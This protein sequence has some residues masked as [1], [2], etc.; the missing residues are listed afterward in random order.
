MVRNANERPIVL[1][2]EELQTLVLALQNPDESI[3]KT[4]FDRLYEGYSAIVWRTALG[5]VKRIEIADEIKQQ[6]FQKVWERRT[7]LN[8]DSN[9]PGL[10]T[11]ISKR[12]ALD[13]IKS[14]RN[15]SSDP[16]AL[17]NLAS[18]EVATVDALITQEELLAYQR[19]RQQLA[20][21]LAP[22]KMAM[23]D[24]YYRLEKTADQIAAEQGVPVATVRTILR[25][26]RLRLQTLVTEAD[27]ALSP[28][29]VDAQTGD[30]LALEQAIRDLPNPAA[31]AALRLQLID[32][33]PI[34]AIAAQLQR[35]PN[36]VGLLLSRYRRILAEQ[37]GGEIPEL[38]S[39]TPRLDALIRTDRSAVIQLIQTVEHAA[40]RTVLLRHLI[41]GLNGS[42][43][44][45]ENQEPENTVRVRIARGKDQLEA[46]LAKRQS[47]RYSNT[48]V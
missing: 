45:Q 21:E 6:T 9:V 43:I 5:I 32:N 10:L 48:A 42:E 36:A 46:K 26:A 41:D 27:T 23:V 2:S 14:P 8:V 47:A 11:T 20:N 44:A 19:A 22:N 31:A 18:D 16:D 7:Q 13:H 29:T 28:A 30:R 3:A 34:K 35:S 17:I 33:L 39:I 15:A 38:H 24:D 12:L 4:A 37:M 25:R 40:T 1:A